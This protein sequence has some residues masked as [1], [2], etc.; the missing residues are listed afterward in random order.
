MQ[1]QDAQGLLQ[2]EALKSCAA[3]L[4]HIEAAKSK[5]EA[6]EA[7]A[8][9]ARGV[10]VLCADAAEKLLAGAA[11]SSSSSST[12]TTAAAVKQQVTLLHESAE[13]L[14]LLLQAAST[15]GAELQRQLLQ[16]QQIQQQHH[17]QQQEDS[18]S[19]EETGFLDELVDYE[20]NDPLEPYLR[21]HLPQ[22]QKASSSRHKALL[23]NRHL[24][25]AWEAFVR[26]LCSSGFRG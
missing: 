26:G 23:Q 6:A 2:Q 25:N 4:R 22:Q 18:S 24:P 9:A 16:Q 13:R 19:A 10:L 11:S 14:Q 1:Q 15:Q 21:C 20:T 8:T 17:M 3:L 12:V 7:T 5:W